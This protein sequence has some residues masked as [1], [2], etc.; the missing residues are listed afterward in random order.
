MK[1]IE[2][3]KCKKLN[4]NDLV[5][6]SIRDC[7]IFFKSIENPPNP[8]AELKKAAEEYKRFSNTSR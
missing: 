3:T 8:N 1:S 7:E 2:Q 4:S 5:L 6:A